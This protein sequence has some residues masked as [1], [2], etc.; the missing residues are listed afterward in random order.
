MEEMIMIIDPTKWN[1]EQDVNDKLEE[2]WSMSAML[3]VGGKAILHL[4]KPKATKEQVGY[5]TTSD[6]SQIAKW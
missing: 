3:E 2:G 4:E 6:P 5:R 1:A